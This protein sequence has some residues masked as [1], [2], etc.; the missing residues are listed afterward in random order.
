ML[1]MLRQF[2]AT[3]PTVLEGSSACSK[4]A[5][6]SPLYS[7]LALSEDRRR[8]LLCVTARFLRWI[9]ISIFT[10]FCFM[11]FIDHF[12]HRRSSWYICGFPASDGVK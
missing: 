11:A 8:A 5:L 2:F 7:V 4:E 10:N 6:R 12:T 3:C 1:K 9:I